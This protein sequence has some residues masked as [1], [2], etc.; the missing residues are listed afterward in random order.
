V[1]N[2]RATKSGGRGQ[3]PGQWILTRARTCPVS[4]N[5][6]AV[7]TPSSPVAKAPMMPKTSGVFARLRRADIG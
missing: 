1:P 5:R 2:P 4:P 6:C 3:G 7:E